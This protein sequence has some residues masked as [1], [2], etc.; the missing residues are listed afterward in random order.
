MKMEMVPG[1]CHLI[2]RNSLISFVMILSFSALS[3]AAT[4]VRKTNIAPLADISTSPWVGT[5]DFVNRYVDG[6]LSLFN[7]FRGGT[8]IPGQITLEW[9]RPYS[10]ESIRFTLPVDDKGHVQAIRYILLADLNGDGK[11]E[12]TLLMPTDS[13][14]VAK[15]RVLVSTKINNP[16]IVTIKPVSIQWLTKDLEGIKVRAIRLQ[17]INAPSFY[18]CSGPSVSEIEVYT[19]D[20]VV[21]SE[22]KS[23]SSIPPHAIKLDLKPSSPPESLTAESSVKKAVFVEGQASPWHGALRKFFENS[24][25]FNQLENE[26]EFKK[27]VQDLKLLGVEELDCLNPMIDDK[28]VWPC[29]SFY[30]P[31]VSNDLL[32]PFVKAMH[33]AGLKVGGSQYAEWPWFP[34]K[35]GRN[36]WPREEYDRLPSSPYPRYTCVISDVFYRNGKT[37]FNRN[38]IGRGDQSLDS[39][40]VVGDEYYYKP[41]H[42]PLPKSDPCHQRFSERFGKPVPETEANTQAYRDWVRFCYEGVAEN[43]EYLSKQAKD[44][45]P[46]LNTVAGLSIDFMLF[47]NRI[48][49]GISPDIVARQA[50]SLDYLVLNPYPEYHG[51]MKHNL[52]TLM[53][54]YGSAAAP[55]G[56]FGMVL[57]GARTSGHV[58][59]R[60][61]RAVDVYG[62]MLSAYIHGARYLSIYRLD[63]LAKTFNDVALGFKTIE[64]LD[65]V[66]FA[67]ARPAKTIALCISRASQDWWWIAHAKDNSA[68]KNRAMVSD[69]M[70]IDFL[71]R[72]GYPFDLYF[73]DYPEELTN[74]GQYDLIILPFPYAVSKEAAKQINLAMD[75]G[76]QVLAMQTPGVVDQNGEALENNNNDLERCLSLSNGHFLPKV[77]LLTDGTKHSFLQELKSQIDSLIGASTPFA[78]N[79]GGYDV[80]ASMYLHP[81]GRVFVPIINWE[82]RKMEFS[83]KLHLVANKSYRLYILK[84][85]GWYEN[86]ALLSPQGVVGLYLDENEFA[87][88]V[89]DPEP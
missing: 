78:L 77:D 50:K 47:Q 11:F 63:Y 68:V 9:D 19:T 8:P 89:L 79:A 52:V 30:R 24:T 73:L 22:S 15:N 45:H 88:L 37:M 27:L 44:Y 76:A 25:S 33:K 28:A 3:L 57:Q 1:S 51:Q 42:L 62:G 21:S 81:E 49:H 56:R 18:L 38:M 53:A 60:L 36:T 23:S 55:G 5:I 10:L 84:P 29:S 48:A 31:S 39:M 54:K 35:A 74:L 40:Y 41:H 65:K 2:T 67:D 70:M 66:G 32:G 59:P 46:E 83:I 43:I 69:E 14:D 58:K 64:A 12:R 4:E 20:S 16:E 6:D 86:T 72:R 82:P 75:D 80:E 13:Q 7:V 87:I 61:F 85:T 34:G 17:A 71:L 26:P